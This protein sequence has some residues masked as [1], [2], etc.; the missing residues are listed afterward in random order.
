[1][2][3]RGTAVEDQAIADLFGEHLAL[4]RRGR[5]VGVMEAFGEKLGVTVVELGRM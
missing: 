5:E 3:E 2:V 4:L 1:M